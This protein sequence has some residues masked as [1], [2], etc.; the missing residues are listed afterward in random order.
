MLGRCSRQ[1][2]YV[3][4]PAEFRMDAELDFAISGDRAA[5]KMLI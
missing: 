4:K 5:R 1:M 3:E 2:L